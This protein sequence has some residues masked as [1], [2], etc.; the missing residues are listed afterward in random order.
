MVS[1]YPPSSWKYWVTAVNLHVRK[2]TKCDSQAGV[3]FRVVLLLV[4]FVELKKGN[5]SCLFSP[6]A[7]PKLFVQQDS[8]TF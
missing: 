8:D 3:D 7:M 5:I 6:P 1:V 4:S 2:F